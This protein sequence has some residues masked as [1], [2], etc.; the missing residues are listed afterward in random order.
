MEVKD[1]I[2]DELTQKEKDLLELD[3]KNKKYK[4][5]RSWIR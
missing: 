1:L 4:G 2:V 5:D 3:I